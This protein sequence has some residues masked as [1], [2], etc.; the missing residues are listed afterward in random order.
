MD[1]FCTIVDTNYI[2]QALALIDSVQ[3]HHPEVS[4]SL[5]ITDMDQPFDYGGEIQVVTPGEL[6]ISDERLLLMLD[7]YDSVELATS[8]KPF[9]LKYLLSKGA[10]SATFID[11]DVLLFSR[12]D[13][14]LAIA[15][16]GSIV[17]TPHRLSP[18]RANDLFYREDTF[19]HYGIYNLGFL[20]I[21][22]K[23]LD[24][25]EWWGK[26][27]TSQCTRYPNEH[28]YTDQKWADHFPVYFNATILRDSGMNVAP[29]N[30]D[31]RE[32]TFKDKQYFSNHSLL[33][34]VHFSQMSGAVLRGESP[35]LWGVMLR[36]SEAEMN[37]LRLL[38][39]LTHKYHLILHSKTESDFL[40]LLFSRAN[41][42]AGKSL[43]YRKYKNSLASRSEIRALKVLNRNKF[44][45][46]LRN[47][48][49]LD[50]VETYGALLNSIPKDLR[51]FRSK[52]RPKS[53]N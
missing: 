24:A 28:I 52:F 22:S 29:W 20:S 7:F 10:D 11:P 16:S 34:F 18:I 12:L 31:E 45:W 49:I 39:E 1:S 14:A 26:I 5:L 44:W 25:L 46:V 33:K 19:L 4:F 38:N 42:R 2:P 21:N 27:L 6:D 36:N 50:S 23:N 35:K 47:F 13:S 40:K 51:R 3:Q 9:L 17:L 8:L 48:R 53:K 43:A 41:K 15:K 37:S 30:L 32:I